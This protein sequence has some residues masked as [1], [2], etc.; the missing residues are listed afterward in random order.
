M[1]GL[2]FIFLP[3]FALLDHHLAQVDQ[4]TRGVADPKAFDI[5]KAQQS[6]CFEQLT[7]IEQP[8]LA[9]P[10]QRP[11]LGRRLQT[12]SSRLCGGVCFAPSST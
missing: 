5:W 8:L 1:R 10:K 7:F 9:T 12:T 11:L 2:E 6:L 3:P 4:G